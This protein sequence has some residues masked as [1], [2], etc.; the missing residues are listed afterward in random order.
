MTTNQIEY[1]KH[2]E[3]VRHQK[4]SEGIESVKAQ[5]QTTSALAAKEQARVAGLQAGVAQGQLAETQR[6]NLEKERVNWWSA[7]E[8]GRHNTEM[9][10]L[11]SRSIASTEKLNYAQGQAALRQA[12]SAASQAETASRRADTEA[13]RV[14]ILGID[15][16]TQR[17]LASVAGMNASTALK[18]AQE[19]ARHNAIVESQKAAEIA[20]SHRHN[21]VGEVVSTRQ[22][23][24]EQAKLPILQQQADAQTTRSKAT[25]SMATSQRINAVAGAINSGYNIVSDL[26]GKAAPA[27]NRQTAIWRLFR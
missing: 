8:T 25:Q 7:T 20:E 16:Q 22:S 2:L 1:A 5:A 3:T 23:Y 9:E 11:Q 13:T 4:A 26:A 15:A 24:T 14:G 10:K 19:V 6:A 18:Q 17:M 12:D 27:I 21:V